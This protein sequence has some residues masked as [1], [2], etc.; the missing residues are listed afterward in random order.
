MNFRYD[1]NGLRAIAVLAVVFFHFAPSFLAGGFAGVDVFFV[2]SGFLMTGIIFKGIENK[3]FSIFSFYKA[4]AKRII[5]AL[6]VLCLTLIAY[7][8]V[9]L[10]P[11]DY[12]KLGKHAL[13]SITFLSNVVYWQESG[14]FDVSSYEKWLLHTW[15]L[16]VEWQFYILYPIMIL[17]LVR[18]FS[19]GRV[20]IIIGAFT[21]IAFLVGCFASYRFPNASYYLL[22]TRAWE[23]L[24]GGIAFL[25]PFSSK[26][27]WRKHL[28]IIGFVFIIL[29]YIFVSSEVP[30]PGYMAFFPVFGSFLIIMSNNQ[31]SLLT[32][33]KF[34]QY[35][36]K[37]SYSIY[38]WHWPIVVFGSYY[39]ENWWFVGIPLSIIFGFFSYHFI[40]QRKFKVNS[41]SF[42]VL[43]IFVPVTCL[44]IYMGKGFD[45]N[46][47][48]ITTSDET[49]Y[50][51][52]YQPD[53]YI[54]DELKAYYGDEC[55]FFDSQLGVAKNRISDT[56][57]D[58]GLGGILIWG[59]SHAQALSYGLKGGYR[60]KPFYQVASS[61]CVPSLKFNS[62][63]SEIE[64][65]CFRSNS[66]AFEVLLDKAPELVIWAQK[67]QHDKT[68]Y[69]SI[70]ETARSKG[71][72]SKF[73]L[74]GPVPQWHP[75]LP[76]VLAK[77]HFT[78]ESRVISDL[79]FDKALFSLDSDTK[80]KYSK[81]DELTYI[82]LINEL[83][84][85]AGCLAK[86]DQNKT[87][88][89]WDYGHLT[90]KGSEYIASNVIWPLIAKDNLI[91]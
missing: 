65:S 4:R 70:I 71:V 51:E 34:F 52:K 78:S 90:P 54:T 86:L 12:M 5:P 64:L 85:E 9:Y 33:N 75:S 44:F 20:K 8:W 61:A 27:R 3:C 29:S 73:V 11:I 74:V 49:K 10:S 2:I 69:L 76:E 1:I 66:K 80:L 59:D 28:E 30:W 87:P 89:V 26:F 25:F 55:N 53:V 38:L 46:F 81:Q 67:N 63:T 7:G 91:D 77:R 32:S 35:I 79:A 50:V 60:D 15:S 43:S 39:F 84:S 18:F 88:L 57:T 21:I 41:F 62:G 36:G 16:S 31:T 17:L 40:E 47:R 19:I 13:S 45:Y 23:M 56:C 22:P 37:W 72:T 42:V 58:E 48:S 83:C 68:D 6:S 24:V 82:S 14:Y